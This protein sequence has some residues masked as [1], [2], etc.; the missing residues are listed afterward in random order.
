[1]K[2]EREFLYKIYLERCKDLKKA[3]FSNESLNE[4]EY[5]KDKLNKEQFKIILNEKQRR[6]NKRNRVGKK[7]EELY[8]IAE[9]INNKNKKIVF[10]T[11]TLDNENLELKEDSYIRKIEKWLKCHFIFV[12]LNKDFG[13]ETE[14]EHYHFIGLTTEEIEYTGHKSKKGYKMYN[15]KEK[16]YKIGHEPNLEIIDKEA[17]D[18]K[19]LIDYLVKEINHSMKI[20]SRVRI[21]KNPIAKMIILTEGLEESKYEKKLKKIYTKKQLKKIFNN[22]KISELRYT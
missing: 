15:L 10:G 19:K 6:K 17:T 2:N 5:F 4:F 16:N 3:N 12:I 11:C 18:I 22:A 13:S 7:Y 21:I 20:K 1:M 14:R 8:K 9:K